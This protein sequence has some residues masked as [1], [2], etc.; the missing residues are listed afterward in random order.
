MGKVLVTGGAGS[1]G[2]HLVD[3]LMVRGDEVCMFDNL[4]TGFLEN[5]RHW[6]GNP[7]FT[8]IKGDLLSPVDLEELEIERYSVIFHL[9]ANPEVKI[10]S[11][12][13]SVHFKQNI[14]VIRKACS[15]PM[16]SIASVDLGRCR[17]FMRQKADDFNHR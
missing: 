11:T 9:A 4:S 14:V 17:L 7:D 6:L 5:V 1:I 8:F 3:A 12:D 2:S 13:P 15:K 16:T 10:G